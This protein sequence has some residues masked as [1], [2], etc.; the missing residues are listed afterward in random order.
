MKTVTIKQEQF[1]AM[2]NAVKHAVSKGVDRPIMQY[3]KVVV[4]AD[5]VTFYALDGYRAAKVTIKQENECEFEC[6]IKPIETKK[7]RRSNESYQTTI[8][9]DEET[10]ATNLTLDMEC[11]AITYRF[12]P[13]TASFIDIESIYDNARKHDRELAANAIFISDA[14]KAI[15]ATSGDNK[16][17]TVVFETRENSCAPFILRSEGA[18]IINEQL[19]L[20]IR[21][22]K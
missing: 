18:A 3:I 19:I 10:R 14:V 4:A 1:Y 16:H 15:A 8:S 11:G 17:K 21:I 2:M 5:S 13:P 22:A 20:P 7:P 6:L 9:Y 12:N